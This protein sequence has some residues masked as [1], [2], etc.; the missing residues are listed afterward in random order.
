[1]STIE[2]S[3]LLVHGVVVPISGTGRADALSAAQRDENDSWEGV[4]DHQIIE[5]GRIQ[6]EPLDEGVVGPTP[7][8][9]RAVVNAV[10]ALRRQVPAPTAVYAAGDGGVVVAW[11]RG[12]DRIKLEIDPSGRSEFKVFCN[13]RLM[14]PMTNRYGH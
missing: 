13:G 6:G 8:A 12:H 5:L 14:S 1:M 9:M 4:I 3:S 2:T 7:Q 10:E 11:D